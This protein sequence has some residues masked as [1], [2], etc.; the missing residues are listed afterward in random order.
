MKNKM[1]SAVRK[2]WVI[3]SIILS[4]WF[5]RKYSLKRNFNIE[6]DKC[7]EISF[8]GGDCKIKC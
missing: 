6:T 8:D 3:K 2:R 1:N 7:C 4:I 5:I